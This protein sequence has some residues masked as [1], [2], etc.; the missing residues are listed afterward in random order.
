[1]PVLNL[2]KQEAKDLHAVMSKIEDNTTD[3][4]DFGESMKSI[5][6]KLNRMK[7][8]GTAEKSAAKEHHE[9]EDT[10]A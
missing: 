4:G 5:M 1:M 10:D 2:S 8:T 9:E 7:Y 3:E 6:N